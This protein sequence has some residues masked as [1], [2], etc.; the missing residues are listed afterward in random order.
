MRTALPSSGSPFF[1]F[2]L[3]P[4]RPLFLRGRPAPFSPAL[5]APRTRRRGVGLCTVAVRHQPEVLDHVPAESRPAETSE[6]EGTHK[7]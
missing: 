2:N 3:Q 1:T 5:P 4:G 7:A 6:L